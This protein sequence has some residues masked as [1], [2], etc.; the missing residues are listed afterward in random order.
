MH[1]HLKSL[2]VCAHH[3]MEVFAPCN[4]LY[5]STTSL[6]ESIVCPKGKYDE[7]YKNECL[8]GECTSCGVQML[9]FCGDEL[10]G[11]DNW[12]VQWKHYALEETRSKNGKTLRKLTL[13]Y[14]NTSSNELI[15]YLR[16][17]FQHF[18]ARWQNEKFKTCVKSFSND[19]IVFIIHYSKFKMK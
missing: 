18:V 7:W 19:C 16:P 3:E 4:V 13:I 9:Q 2:K 15:E 17:K 5:K 12:Q 8:Y 6:L 11:L 10:S 14:K 1:G